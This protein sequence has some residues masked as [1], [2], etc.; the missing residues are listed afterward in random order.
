ML[1]N[2]VREMISEGLIKTKESKTAEEKVLVGA[3]NK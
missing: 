2:A 3:G 1:P